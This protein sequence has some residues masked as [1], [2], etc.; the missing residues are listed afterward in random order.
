MLRIQNDVFSLLHDFPDTSVILLYINPWI[1]FNS[2]I[3]LQYFYIC[4][5]VWRSAFSSITTL[6]TNSSLQLVCANV[7]YHVHHSFLF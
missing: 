1:C 7:C 3:P 5:I 2:F 6:N 4:V